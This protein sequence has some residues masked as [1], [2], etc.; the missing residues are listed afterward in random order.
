MWALWFEV[1]PRAVIIF[2][3]SLA[4]SEIFIQIRWRLSLVCP[5]C[6]FDPLVYLKSPDRAAERVRRHFDS[7][8]ESTSYVMGYHPLQKR[9]RESKRKV[10]NNRQRATAPRKL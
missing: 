8:Q 6:Q 9:L 4:I 10:K 2:V 5:H 7:I 1:D 3:L